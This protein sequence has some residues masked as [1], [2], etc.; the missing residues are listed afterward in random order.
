MCAFAH[1]PFDRSLNQI[2]LLKI[3]SGD[4][5]EPVRCILKTYDISE[6]KEYFALSYTWGPE[7]PQRRIEI[8]GLAFFVRQNLFDFL[9]VARSRSTEGLFWIDQIYIDQVNFRERNHQV[10]LMSSIY[11]DASCVVAWL[12]AASADSDLAITYLH[13][14]DER[15]M[16]V[17]VTF[18]EETSPQVRNSLAALF[19]RP[20]WSRLWIIQEVVLARKVELLCGSL[21]LKWSKV[22]DFVVY[23]HSTRITDTVSTR[24]TKLFYINKPLVYL[25]SAKQTGSS[26][27]S[28]LL[29][30]WISDEGASKESFR[31]SIYRCCDSECSDLRDKIYGLLGISNVHARGVE[32]DYSKSTAAVFWDFSVTHIDGIEHIRDDGTGRPIKL[33]I[34]EV[35]DDWWHYALRIMSSMGVN[36]PWLRKNVATLLVE[37]FEVLQQDWLSKG[38]LQVEEQR[39]ISSFFNRRLQSADSRAS[40]ELKA[41]HLGTE[42]SYFNSDQDYDSLFDQYVDLA[43]F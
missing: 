43:G 16:W 13:N 3:W 29:E 9:V 6:A 24:I 15:R 20:Y 11:A 27:R 25:G 23:L 19:A 18:L 42:S 40:E 21:K 8:N 4:Q 7:F 28:F 41:S 12:G 33:S 10:S 1:P 36:Q 22:R 26:A 5:E 17:P 32:V 39:D 14:I 31:A 37:T 34:E 38:L 30:P 35:L 2:R